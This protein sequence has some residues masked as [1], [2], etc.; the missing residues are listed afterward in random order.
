MNLEDQDF[1]QFNPDGMFPDDLRQWHDLFVILALYCQ[2]K[3]RAMRLRES[4]EIGK[5]LEIESSLDRLYQTIP[6]GFRW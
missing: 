5:A 1:E 2:D 6:K 3:E 4:G